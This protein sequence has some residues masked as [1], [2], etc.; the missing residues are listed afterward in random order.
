MKDDGNTF[1]FHL[2]DATWHDGTTVTAD[3]IIFSLDRMAQE[4]V[5]RGR[6]PAIRTFYERGTATEIDEKT[7][8]MPL[9]FPSATALGWLAVDYFAMYPRALENVSQ[10]DFNCCFENSYGS[11]PWIQTEWKKGDSYSYDRYD[12]YFKNPQPYADGLKVFI[13]KDYARRLATL[14][15]RQVIGMLY[16]SGSWLPEDMLQI[17]KET[18]GGMRFAKTAVAPPRPCL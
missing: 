9:K 14:K 15:T 17:Q 10:D 1:I 16:M 4:G 5:T 8:K 18:N 13:I 7:V 3:D 11:G 12:N 6:V 2:Q